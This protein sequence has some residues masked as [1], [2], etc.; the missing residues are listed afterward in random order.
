MSPPGELRNWLLKQLHPLSWSEFG[1][2][3]HRLD[4]AKGDVLHRQGE[5]IDQVYFPEGALVGLISAM[6]AGDTVQTAMVGWD[7]ALGVFEACGTRRS[8]FLAEVQVAGSAW[9]LP[10][11]DYRALFEASEPLRVAVHKYVELLL[12]EARQF[13]ACNALHAVEGRLCRSILEALERSRDGRSLPVTQEALAEM[14]GVQRTT[15]TAAV[16]QL[17]AQGVLR[18]RRGVV[19]VLDLP[20]LEQGACCCRDTLQLARAEIHAAD[21]TVCNS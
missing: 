9:R 2:R 13:V 12:T 10:A 17:Q 4:L 7:G 19:Q 14:L 1:A 5:P 3:F 15:V 8:T 21:E 16:S 6:P 18:S 20:A 11:E